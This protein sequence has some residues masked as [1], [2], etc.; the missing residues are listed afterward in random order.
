L[1]P[2]P[3]SSLRVC[4]PPAPKAGGGGVHTRRVGRGWGGLYFGRRHTMDWPLTVSSLYG[5]HYLAVTSVCMGSINQLLFMM[6]TYEVGAGIQAG[7]CLISGG[8]EPDDYLESQRR[9][10]EVRFPYFP[11]RGHSAVKIYNFTRLWSHSMVSLQS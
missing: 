7:F 9:R 10:R 2:H 3:L 6:I 11:T 5:L 4:P 1:T 8:R